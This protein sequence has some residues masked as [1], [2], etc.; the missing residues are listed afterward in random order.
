MRDDK[1]GR[2]QVM[3]D[4]CC[5]LA[6]RSYTV[7]REALVIIRAMRNKGHN[8]SLWDTQNNSLSRFRL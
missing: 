3:H 1:N 8:V 2:Y 7:K 6:T 5:K 4:G